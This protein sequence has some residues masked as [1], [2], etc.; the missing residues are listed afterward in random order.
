MFFVTPRVWS[1]LFDHIQAIIDWGR[2]VRFCDNGNINIMRSP[3]NYV[4]IAV[5]YGAFS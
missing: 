2:E 3:G 5:R 4:L 1:L